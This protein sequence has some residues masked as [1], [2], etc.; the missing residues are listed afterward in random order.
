MQQL[1]V[2]QMRP[3]TEEAMQTLP[4]TSDNTVAT[5]GDLVAGKGA[6]LAA[7]Q[8]N[9]VD[10]HQQFQ[11]S[12]NVEAV[13][14]QMQNRQRAADSQQAAAQSQVLSGYGGSTHAEKQPLQHDAI[15]RQHDEMRNLVR[16]LRPEQQ[17]LVANANLARTIRGYPDQFFI[18]T[19][20]QS[21][22]TTSLSSFSQQI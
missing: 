10:F 17:S 6:N 22:T 5:V 8:S 3:L 2:R 16:S 4:K 1:S 13:L 21:R 15:L 19:P 7:L 12:K 18:G 11:Q 14:Q 20:S 9:P